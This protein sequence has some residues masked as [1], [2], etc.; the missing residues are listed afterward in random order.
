MFRRIMNVIW[1][2][3]N[4][5]VKKRRGFQCYHLW[6]KSIALS[7]LRLCLVNLLLASVILF[8]E[9]RENSLSA[10]M[11]KYSILLRETFKIENLV[12]NNELVIS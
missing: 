1:I 2:F 12:K 10:E 5:G 8:K 3:V 6:S 4:F 11:L 9:K 7:Q